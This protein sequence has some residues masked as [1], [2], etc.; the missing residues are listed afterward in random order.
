MQTPISYSHRSE[1]LHAYRFIATL[2]NECYIQPKVVEGLM[3][4]VYEETFKYQNKLWSKITLDRLKK[5]N[6]GT[7][8]LQKFAF[9]QMKRVWKILRML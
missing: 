3:R 6:I 4:T 7:N 5:N 1:S 2:C 9:S 8:D